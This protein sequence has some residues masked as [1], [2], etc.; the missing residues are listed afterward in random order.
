M[1]TYAGALGAS[2]L[3]EDDEFYV[4]GVLEGE[5][6]RIAE[7]TDSINAFGHTPLC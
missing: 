1:E 2:I 5:H 3:S 7:I 6:V 4:A